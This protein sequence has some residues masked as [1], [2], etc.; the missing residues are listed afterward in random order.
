M[1]SPQTRA[2]TVL[3]L[4][5]LTHELGPEPEAITDHEKCNYSARPHD[6]CD[7]SR[8]Q[9]DGG[10]PRK[11]LAWIGRIR[12]NHEPVPEPENAR[13]SLQLARAADPVALHAF[14]EVAEP[15]ASRSLTGRGIEPIVVTPPT[16]GCRRQLVQYRVAVSTARYGTEARAVT[17]LKACSEWLLNRVPYR[18]TNFEGGC[19]GKACSD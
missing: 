7:L 19:I 11:T 12:L 16:Q 4:L 13:I 6:P 8:C 17:L 14:Y 3:T 15:L 10:C 2:C 18:I 5:E 1:C 9:F